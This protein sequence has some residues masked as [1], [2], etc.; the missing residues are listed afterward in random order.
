[1]NVYDVLKNENT[2]ISV[3]WRWLI[4]ESSGE[5]VVYES[6]YRQRKSK[7]IY[8]GTD[9]QEACKILIEDYL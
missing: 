2:R 8:W 5:F 7:V 4:I 1:M 6:K 3:G 9:E